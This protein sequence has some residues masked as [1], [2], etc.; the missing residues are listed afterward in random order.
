M[1]RNRM[2]FLFIVLF[3][4]VLG[5]GSS[6]SAEEET[7]T[8]EY[9]QENTVDTNVKAMK[10]PPNFAPSE[11]AWV[12]FDTREGAAVPEGTR[13][14][15]LRV[16][17]PADIRG[18]ESFFF[19]TIDQS[20]RVYLDGSTIYRYGSSD[21][22]LEK[23]GRKW[24]LV[25]LPAWAAGR[26]LIV[27]VTSDNPWVLTQLNRVHIDKESELVKRIFIY[28][29]PY[30]AGVTAIIIFMMVIGV[31]FVVDAARRSIYLRL[32]L[33][34]T[35]FF[36]WMFSSTNLIFMWM[37][38]PVLW[39]RTEL[40]SSYLLPV[41]GSILL[42]E[43][44]NR[45]YRSWIMRLNNIFVVLLVV[46]II[47][48]MMGKFGLYMMQFP[49]VPGLAVWGSYVAY[50]LWKSS[51][52]GN[53]HAASLLIALLI[54][55]P[56]GI[57][58]ALA[59]QYRLY[60]GQS[61]FT[62]FSIYTIGFFIIQLILDRAEAER[63]LL[64]HASKLEEEVVEVK[65]RMEI[66]PL[67][68]IY[69]RNRFPSAMRDF[70]KIA[71]DTGE[72]LSLVMFDIDHFKSINDTYGHDA[73]DEVLYGFSQKILSFLDRRHVLIRWGG[74]EF[75]LLCLHYDGDQ[76]KAFADQIREGVAEA[77]LLPE[78]QVT[79][80]GGVGV[81]NGSSDDTTTLVKRA[82]TA[83]YA[84]KENGRNRITCEP[85][86]QKHMP[87]RRPKEKAHDKE[88]RGESAKN[89]VVDLRR[90]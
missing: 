78:R 10:T 18:D 50:A 22:Q 71:R 75:I 9:W 33:F 52:A 57:I 20:V 35:T 45:Q 58:D 73:G 4:L 64:E 87:P 76:A 38:W 28:D 85:D 44:V 68:G 19:A 72:P 24:H 84:S 36:V 43:V 17:V 60:E 90:R 5:I 80:S 70:T 53:K 15:W 61:F 63:Q 41:T 69:N 83:L 65:K 77:R 47:V 27:R 49:Y 37:D 51:K 7:L 86:W 32:M 12:P 89:N 42:V 14:A 56:L 62:P 66:D 13:N 11:G 1:K 6:A 67:T 40:I 55:V 21:P 3:V 46:G 79:C 74:E 54:I 88:Q 59:F 39:W 16:H 82:D 29:F 30:V 2:S 23:Y 25:N 48:E 26:E 31:Y 34:L 8:W 81:W